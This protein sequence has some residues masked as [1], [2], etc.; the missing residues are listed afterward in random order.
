MSKPKPGILVFASGTKDGGGSGFENLVNK[1]RDNNLN[2]K[3]IGVVSNHKDGGVKRIAEKLNVPFHLF[4]EISAENYRKIVQE[5]GANFV[6]LSGWLKLVT[7]LDPRTTFNIHPAPL[8]QFGGSGMYG[9]FAHE[10]V[11]KAYH[12]KK[13]SHTE[14]TMHFV[15]EKYDEGPV[16]FRHPVRIEQ[17]DTPET[18]AERVKEAEHFFQPTI[19]ELVVNGKIR[20][21]GKNLKSLITPY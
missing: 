15:T 3:I 8:P 6:A 12:E 7:G 14:M 21:D 13:I 16:F 5:T 1:T 18:L 9:H 19:T 4:R 11:M 20:W 10:A 17:N 2:M